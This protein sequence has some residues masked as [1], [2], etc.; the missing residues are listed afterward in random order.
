[1]TTSILFDNL[2]KA[3]TTIHDII[4][5]LTLGGFNL[6][7]FISNNRNILKNLSRET[8]SSKVLNLDLKELPTDRALG[9]IW[10]SNYRYS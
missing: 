5:L 8:L 4:R 3:I 9:I 10:D 1:M 7:K 6:A 2:D